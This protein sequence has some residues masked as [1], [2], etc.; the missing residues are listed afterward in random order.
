MG[1]KHRFMI[2]VMVGILDWLGR[3]EGGVGLGYVP[4]FR[5][6]GVYFVY[7]GSGCGGVVGLGVL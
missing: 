2:V 7:L 5:I 3:G 6:F 4:C 1:G